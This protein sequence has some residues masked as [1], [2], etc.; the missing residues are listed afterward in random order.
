M[1]RTSFWPVIPMIIL[2]FL[3][4]ACGSAAAPAP[5][6]LKITLPMGYIPDPQFA[7]FY[8]AIDKGDFA[9]AGFDVELDY[10][11]ETDGVSLV[12]AGEEPFAV[13]SGDVVLSAR[14]EGVPIVYVMEWYQ[15]YPI[16]VVSLADRGIEAPADLP[17]RKVGIPGL[18]GAT[19]VGYAGL[20]AA[21]QI[22]PAAVNLEEIGFN[23]VESLLSGQV[24]A[25]LVYVNNEPVQ[26]ANRGD[27]IDV[28]KISDY[29]DLVASGLV[30]NEQFAAANP[31]RVRGFVGAVVRGLQDTLDNPDEAFEISKKYVE[32]LDESRR[33]VLDASLD[34]WR[35][36]R[37]GFTD[38]VSWETTQETLIR[39]GF[40]SGPLADLQA[41]YSNDFL[42]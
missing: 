17:G 13:V 4:S 19:Y 31:E 3:G 11:F 7:P 35:A 25:A 14:A 12:G 6:T 36:D 33:G 15:Q 26:L 20:L 24:E 27:A 18:F 38:P 2:L 42:P 28:I 40:L 5:E 30:T 8:V 32:G 10:S 21:N 41:A 34:L 37:L 29:I 9:G 16:A 22:D 23:Q 39:M 1:K